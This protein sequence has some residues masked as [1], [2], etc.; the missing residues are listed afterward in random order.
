MFCTGLWTCE[1]EL[2]LIKVNNSLSA[3]LSIILFQKTAWT[4]RLQLE[5]KLSARACSS[6]SRSNSGCYYLGGHFTPIPLPGP[7]LR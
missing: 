7:E 2:A 5:P 1:D 4:P 3:Q 6:N